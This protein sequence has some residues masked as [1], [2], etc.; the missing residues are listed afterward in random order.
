MS[1]TGLGLQWDFII[2]HETA[3]EWWGNNISAQDH[4]D[5]WV[6]ESFG[7]YAEGIYTECRLGKIA[8]AAY[9]IGTR[10]GIRND[11]PIIPAFGVNAQGSGDMYPK[12]GNML[13]TIRAIIDDDA[14]WRDILR[15]LNKTFYHRTVTGKQV[16]DFI[17]R[18]AGMD[19]SKVFAQ[20]LTTTQIP[21]FEYRVRDG[22]LD[23]RPGGDRQHSQDQHR[24]RLG[25]PRRLGIEGMPS[26]PTAEGTG[27]PASRPRSG[28][29]PRRFS[30][31]STPGS[32]RGTPRKPYGR[33][34]YR[35]QG[36]GR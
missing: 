9:I 28:R 34:A 23:E 5:M 29:A 18:E 27:H 22:G 25:R 3:H 17:S 15:G 20:Y 8:G 1:G 32:H 7:N 10:A 24:G 6:H 12:G 4:A 19:L 30:V 16:Q 36:P 21:V 33:D 13:H 35:R 14:K 31:E 2:V 11:R 26:H